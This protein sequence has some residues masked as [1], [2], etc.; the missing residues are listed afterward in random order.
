ML[1]RIIPHELAGTV[2]AIASKS[3]AHRLIICAAL[4]DKPT[5]V[6]C[7]STCADIDATARCLNA[8]GAHVEPGLD[9]FTVTPVPREERLEGTVFKPR[10]DAVLDCGESGSTLRFILPV[11]AALGADPVLTGA[12]R[13]AERPLTPLLTEMFIGGCTFSPEG[14]FP[15]ACR[16]TL[17]PG[18]FRLP[19]NVS[20]QYVSGL[21]MAAL[22][23]SSPLTVEV[24]GP[25]QS[26]PYVDLTVRALSEF[27]VAVDEKHFKPT[28]VSVERTVFTVDG[29]SCASPGTTGVEGD[30]SNAA[31]W[32]AAGAVG[33]QTV[34]V[35]GL[36]LNSP[37]G[38]RAIMAALLRFGAKAF[39]GGGCARVQPGRLHGYTFSA[40]DIPDLVPV[41]A[42]VASVAEGETRI[43][44]CER[45]RIKESDRLATTAETLNAL[46]AQVRV[47]GDDLVIQGVD[48]LTGGTV[49]SHNDHRIAMAAAVA[50]I[51]ADGP[52]TIQGAEAVSKSYPGFFTDYRL[53]GGEVLL[54]E[55]PA[56]LERA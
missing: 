15:L 4:A 26:R 55:T 33:G 54:A 7:E 10:R 24:L 19:G 39:R 43:T 12:G 44:D 21:L 23:M 20:S 40:A 37:Q 5:F 16:G 8:L 13:L 29:R 46:G 34:A 38:D 32:L 49:S 25:L 45:L 11:A 22:A 36:D 41:L 9:G 28:T 50:A 31:F 52:V 56:E 1:A 35:E 42:A 48:H 3:V 18:L 14:R 2:P 53:L 6:R 17:R 30:W 27:G 47:E 51:R